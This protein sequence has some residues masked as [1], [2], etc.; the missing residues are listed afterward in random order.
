MKGVGT[1]SWNM[2]ERGEERGMASVR[3]GG[4]LA[5]VTMPRWGKVGLGVI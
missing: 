3:F 2:H 5:S 4:A 1:W